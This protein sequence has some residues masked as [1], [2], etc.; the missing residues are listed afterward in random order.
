MMDPFG[1]P[2]RYSSEPQPHKEKVE[3]G[4]WTI[5]TIKFAV[6]V[7]L[8]NEVLGSPSGNASFTTRLGYPEGGCLLL[9]GHI[10]WSKFSLEWK[11]SM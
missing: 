9:S 10:L 8:L 3:A 7:E 6:F 11:S 2:K 5:S 4:L 1:L